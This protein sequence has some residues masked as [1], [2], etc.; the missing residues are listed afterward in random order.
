VLYVFQGLLVLSLSETGAAGD[1][2]AETLPV[3]GGILGKLKGLP[4][5]TVGSQ[6]VVSTSQKMPTCG[7]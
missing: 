7:E 2:E 3:G 5:G 1:A 4:I 6:M